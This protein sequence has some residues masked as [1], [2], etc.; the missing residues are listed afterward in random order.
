MNGSWLEAMLMPLGFD[1]HGVRTIAI[2]CTI[3]SLVMLLLSLTVGITFWGF[4]YAWISCTIMVMIN[5]YYPFRN[6][7]S[8][9]RLYTGV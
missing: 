4:V 1:E 6:I 8:R 9:I 7:Y 5:H 2:W 3:F